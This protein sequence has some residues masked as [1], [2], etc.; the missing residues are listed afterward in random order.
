M[1]SSIAIS[2]WSD[3]ARFFHVSGKV[4]AS[5]EPHDMRLQRM[6]G[7]ISA[8]YHAKPQS[9]LIVGFGAGVTAGSFVLHPD[10]KRI[11]ICE[12]EPLIPPAASQ[13][14]AAQNYNLLNDPSSRWS[15]TTR[16]T[17]S[18]PARKNS[19]SSHRS[20]SSLGQRRRNALFQRI[21]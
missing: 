13:F 21:F 1:N 20:Y 10:I 18:S 12:I 3:G 14:F 6:L 9:V 19:T 15:M 16:G 17:T 8:L 11:V 2:Q 4:E 5:T 7:H